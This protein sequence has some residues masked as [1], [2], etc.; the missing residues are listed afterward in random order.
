MFDFR[1]YHFV[2]SGA[3]CTCLFQLEEVPSVS[4]GY[5]LLQ[6]CQW[7]KGLFKK[8][9]LYGITQNDFYFIFLLFRFCILFL[10][11]QH[12]CY[13]SLYIYLQMYVFTLTVLNTRRVPNGM[14]HVI[15]HVNVW[16]LQRISTIV[17]QGKA[18]TFVLIAYRVCMFVDNFELQTKP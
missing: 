13:A 5:I 12:A 4:Y 16:I 10:T 11:D 7:D 9:I 1:F 8:K 3:I 18:Y 2:Y 14:M 15:T 17:P 6:Y